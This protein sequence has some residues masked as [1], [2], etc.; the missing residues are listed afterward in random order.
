V[1]GCECEQRLRPWCRGDAVLAGDQAEW[2]E[3]I[4]YEVRDV[5]ATHPA[6]ADHRDPVG[7]RGD[8]A[9]AVRRFEDVREQFGECD[10]LTVGAAGQEDGSGQAR[11]GE[12]AE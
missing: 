8:V 2:H 4:R 12:L 1:P 5:G 9:G 3:P 6:G 7:N 10:D 11:P